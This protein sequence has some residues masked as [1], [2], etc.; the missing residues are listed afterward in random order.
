MMVSV[1]LM[2]MNYLVAKEFFFICFFFF[3]KCEEILC[4]YFAVQGIRFLMTVQ[5]SR[6]KSLS[7]S[8]IT[9]S[10]LSWGRY[11]RT[12]IVI[13]LREYKGKNHLEGTW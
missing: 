5:L 6:E 4:L 13:R 2:L 10:R 8:G 11:K 12:F 1:P 7:I 3:W 9:V